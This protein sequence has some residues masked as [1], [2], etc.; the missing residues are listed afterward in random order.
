MAVLAVAHR[1]VEADR[2]AAHG[3]HAAGLVDARLARRWRSP[4]SSARGRTSCSS[5]R[6]T[7]R[8]LRHRFHHVHGD[9]D[10]AALIGHGAGDRLANPPRGVG[11]ELEA[12]AILEL[13]DRPHQA[14][15]ALL[16]QVEEAQAAVAVLLG[17]RDHQPQVA[18]RKTALRL[19]GSG[20]KSS[21]STLTRFR[22]LVGDSCVARRMLRNSVSH[23]S[24]CCGRPLFRAMVV[25]AALELVHPAAELLQRLD[26]RLDPLRPQAELLD[27]ADRPAAA[28][29]QTAPGG[30]P[31]GRGPRLA[32]GQVVVVLVALQAA[33]PRCADSR[34]GG[35]GSALFPVGRSPRPAPCGRKANR[36]RGPAAGPSRPS[37]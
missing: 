26:H 5:L 29:A 23:G 22:R 11:A 17:D 31:L 36:P 6:D 14:G 10:G 4:R 7:F 25:D 13:V 37:A 3:Q 9:A 30:P 27:Q 16:D 32:R 34:A 21:L 19:P 24:R 35:P 8:T 15:V 33:F 2:I 20:R 28:A 12:A 1:A 18:F